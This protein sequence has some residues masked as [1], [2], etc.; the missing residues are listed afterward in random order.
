MTRKLSVSPFRLACQRTSIKRRHMHSFDGSGGIKGPEK[1]YGRGGRERGGASQQ[2]DEGQMHGSEGKGGRSSSWFSSAAV[3]KL[4][5]GNVSVCCDIARSSAAVEKWSFG[6]V[7]VCCDI[8]RVP[9]VRGCRGASAGVVQSTRGYPPL[10]V[11]LTELKIF[12]SGQSETATVLKQ[13]NKDFFATDFPFF[14]L[15]ASG[16]GSDQFGEVVE[17]S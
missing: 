11:F 16:S 9:R 10:I 17:R 5:S 13:P 7:S 12:S 6:N 8:A 3:E 14:D 1:W 4:S 15:L 2:G